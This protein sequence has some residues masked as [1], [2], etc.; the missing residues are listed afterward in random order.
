[1]LAYLRLCRLPTLFTALSN[2]YAGFLLSHAGLIPLGDFLLLAGATTGLYLSGMVFN[3][4]FDVDQDSRERPQRPIPSGQI[5]RRNAALFGA[6]LMAFGLACAGAASWVSLTIAIALSVSI[7]IYDS[8]L[9]RTVFGPAGMGVCRTL[10]LLLGASSVSDRISGPFQQPLLWYAI[11][12]G[13]YITGVTLFAKHEAEQNKRGPLILS[14][15]IIDLGLIGIA[16]WLADLAHLF[17]VVIPPGALT[18]TTSIFSL[19]GVIALTINR[20]LIAAIMEPTPQRIQPAVE[21]MLL[22]LIVLDAMVIYFKMGSVGGGIG[23]A[24][25]AVALMVPA[26]FLRRFIPMT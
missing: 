25:G 24:I 17:G 1:M 3:D 21:V 13:I 18:S 8:I 4:V 2:L 23:Y 5:S 12:I 11:C 16:V 22:S 26:I 15:V 20:R 7:M 6:G 10:N 14:L 19:W 9:K